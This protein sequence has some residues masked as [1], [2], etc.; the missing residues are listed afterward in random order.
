MKKFRPTPMT[1][2][3]LRTRGQSNASLLLECN[4]WRENRIDLG[5]YFCLY[6]VIWLP[7]ALASGLF[8]YDNFIETNCDEFV[9]IRTKSGVKSS[10]P[11]LCR[12]RKIIMEQDKSE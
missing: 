7:L 6:A 3:P 2:L 10:R 1:L 4:Q 9:K 8:E 5:R 11:N 12:R